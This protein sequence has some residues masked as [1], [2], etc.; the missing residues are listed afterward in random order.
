MN[1]RVLHFFSF[2]D[3]T[4][5]VWLSKTIR[6]G[7]LIEQ[8]L[9]AVYGCLFMTVLRFKYL[10]IVFDTTTFHKKCQILF[11]ITLLAFKKIANLNNS[12]IS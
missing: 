7:F 5:S 1:F 11:D 9:M 3:K 8:N 4:C 12:S 6:I 2:L 10:F